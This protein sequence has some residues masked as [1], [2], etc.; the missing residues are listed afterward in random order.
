MGENVPEA[1]VVLLGST[2]VGKTTLVTH[3][4][5]GEFDPSI[6]ATVGACY[7]SKTFTV[8][9]KQIKLQIWDTAGQER[10]KTLVPMYFRGSKVAI[11]CFAVDDEKS[12]TEV[13]FWAQS[14]KNGANPPPVIFI[15][16]N[17]IDLVDTRVVTTEK[18]KEIAAKWDAKYFEVSAQAGTNVTEMITAV[19]E[20]ALSQIKDAEGAGGTQVVSIKPDKKQKKGCC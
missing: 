1:K 14:V 10:F 20:V 8:N 17:K 9:D 5:T 3:V 7:A 16:A 2:M 15:V 18:G 11:V 19:A 4:T 6:K 13:D 12:L